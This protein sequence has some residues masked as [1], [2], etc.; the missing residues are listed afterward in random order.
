MKIRLK[1]FIRPTAVWLP[2]FLS[3]IFPWNPSAV[4]GGTTSLNSDD[5]SSVRHR[6]ADRLKVLW[7]LENRM[8]SQKSL[9]KVKDKILHLSD[10]KARLIVSLSEL[11]ANEGNTAGADIDFLL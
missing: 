2:L 9:E 3:L 8:G 5:S 10:G 6:D 1:K 4:M 7:V 11:V